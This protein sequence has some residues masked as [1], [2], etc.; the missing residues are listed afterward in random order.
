MHAC[1]YIY[2]FNFYPISSLLLRVGTGKYEISNR[3]DDLLLILPC[4]RLFF[5]LSL[6]LF[7]YSSLF[8]SLSHSLWLCVAIWLEANK[9]LGQ[10]YI[11]V[12]TTFERMKNYFFSL[13]VYNIYLLLFISSCLLIYVYDLYLT[14]YIN[15]LFLYFFFDLNLMFKI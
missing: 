13:Y 1:I 2:I 12:R 10:N 15:H 4:A 6:S 7:I 9:W 8:I 5:F 3:L 14:S 11:T